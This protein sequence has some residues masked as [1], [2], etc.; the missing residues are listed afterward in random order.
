VSDH[1]P[2]IGLLL[3]IVAGIVFGVSFGLAMLIVIFIYRFRSAI[4]DPLWND[5]FISKN[6]AAGYTG[7][8]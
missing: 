3:A 7:V 8:L 5:L 6:C 1:V 4:H 2:L